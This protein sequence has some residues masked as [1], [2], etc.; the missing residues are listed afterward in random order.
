MCIIN[1]QFKH[2][3]KYFVKSLVQILFIMLLNNRS[4]DKFFLGSTFL[5]QLI[6]KLDTFLSWLNRAVKY[7]TLSL[8]SLAVRKS[9]AEFML[10]KALF[11]GTFCSPSFPLH[12]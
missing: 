7:A 6:M 1:G 10:G 9:R 12:L 5:K 11:N 8:L 4:H 3:S 2:S